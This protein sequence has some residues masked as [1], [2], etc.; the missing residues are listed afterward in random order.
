MKKII[1][2]LLGLIIVISAGKS[3][4]YGVDSTTLNAAS[5]TGTVHLNGNTIYIMKGFNYVRNGAV[6]VIDPGA[7]ILGDKPTSGALIVERGG[8]IYANGTVDKPITFTS[9]FAPGNRHPGDWA[10][11]IL[12][13]RA[14]INTVTGVDSAQIEGFPAG[15]GPWYGGQPIV[16]DDSSGVLRYVRIEFPGVNL[17]SVPG[18]EIN[19]LTCGGIGSRTVI[20]HVQISYSGDDAIECFGGTVNLKYIIAL[21]SVDDDFDC[22]NG[23]RGMYQFG[24]A[25]RDSNIYDVSGS[26]NFEI[27]NN[28]NNPSNFNTPRT[29]VVFSNI[30]AVGPNVYNNP[31]FLRNAHLRRN[32]LASIFNSIVMAYPTGIR[33]DGSGVANACMGDTIEIRH[34]IFAGQERLADSAGGTNFSGTAWLQTGS[35]SNRIFTTNSAVMLNNPFNLYPLPAP[36]ANNINFWMPA[37][38]SPAL[39]GAS[40]SDPLLNGFEQT[41]YVGAFGSDNW[42]AGWANFNP[43]MYSPSP[44]GIK[45]IST[46]VPGTF[47]LTQNYPNPFNPATMIKFSIPQTGFT[48]LRVYDMLG[49]EVAEIVNDNLQAGT[50]E[51]NFDASNLSSG[52]YFYKLSVNTSQGVNWTET[53]K[54]VLVK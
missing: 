28:A 19:G 14:G 46:E 17:T 22:D 43:Q 24:L 2:L 41:T 4:S 34:N 30:T 37:G 54:M 51:V 8:K 23:F 13:G 20:E 26:H 16:N 38:G 12:L 49:R 6:I 27:D 11:I 9:R 10:G 36:P 39:T 53:K 42:T 15:Q 21:G 3:Y 35:F 45:Q 1:S 32:M 47:S 7:L 40:F 31:L 50:F 33:F 25:V 5:I 44:I 29:R 48:S 18:N 52:T